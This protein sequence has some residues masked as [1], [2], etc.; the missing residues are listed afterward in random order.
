MKKIMKVKE[1]TLEEDE[2]KD[3]NAR[4]LDLI[5][6]MMSKQYPGVVTFQIACLLAEENAYPGM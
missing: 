2:L 1:A 5:R 4:L 6:A 3:Y